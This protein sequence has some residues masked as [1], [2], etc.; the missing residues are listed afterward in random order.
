M[1]EAVGWQGRG[2]RCERIEGEDRRRGERCER[3]KGG[4]RQGR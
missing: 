3:I 1:R 4:E 2:E